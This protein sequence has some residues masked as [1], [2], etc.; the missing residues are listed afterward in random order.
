VQIR[1]CGIDQ[2]GPDKSRNRTSAYRT[3]PVRPQLPLIP[4]RSIRI[5]LAEMETELLKR[6]QE[7]RRQSELT[8]IG[9]VHIEL[10]VALTNIKVAK[11]RK[12]LNLPIDAYLHLA[13]HALGVAEKMMWR[14]RLRHTN[15][16]R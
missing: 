14:F 2:F 13:G 5:Q 6:M 9:L 7:S 8:A 15:E 16:E 10:A 12:A 11:T 1:R 4:W 3:D